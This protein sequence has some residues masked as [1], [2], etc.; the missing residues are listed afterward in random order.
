[1]YTN[2]NEFTVTK[3]IFSGFLAT[4]STEEDEWAAR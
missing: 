2:Q 3:R 4:M 1:M